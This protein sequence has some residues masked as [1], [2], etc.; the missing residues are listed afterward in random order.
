MASKWAAVVMTATLATT[1]G[2]SGCGG[3]HVDRVKLKNKLEETTFDVGPGL[4]SDKQVNCYA[5][6]LIKTANSSD[7]AEYISG[8][9]QYT[10]IRLRDKKS[11]WEGKATCIPDGHYFPI[12]PSWR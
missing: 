9:K 5:G 6:L 10:Q 7:L 1:L 4:T 8:K 12:S 2:L 11:F 3:G